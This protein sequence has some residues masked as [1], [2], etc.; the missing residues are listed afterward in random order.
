MS[1]SG[2]SRKLDIL[3][4]WCYFCAVPEIRTRN[5][6][7]NYIYSKNFLSLKN[8]IMRWPSVFLQ[9]DKCSIPNWDLGITDK[10]P[11]AQ[12]ERFKLLQPLFRRDINKSVFT[13]LFLRFT[14]WNNELSLDMVLILL[15]TWAQL[16][17]SVVSV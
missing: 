3:M 5:E 2:K 14:V 13:I 6:L 10:S 15:D 11:R 4:V 17:R 9:L 16:K 1:S 12:S 8:S 7:G